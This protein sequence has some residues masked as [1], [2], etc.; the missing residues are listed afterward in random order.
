MTKDEELEELR[1]EN[2]ALREGLEQ[3]R[4]ANE[5]LREGLKHA[6]V[7]IGSEPRACESPRRAD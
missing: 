3:S 2:R 7:A 4:Q 5:N 6:I 1:E